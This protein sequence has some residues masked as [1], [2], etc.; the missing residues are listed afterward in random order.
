[1]STDRQISLD[2]LLADPAAAIEVTSEQ[3]AALLARLGR[4]QAMLMQRVAAEGVSVA[5]MDAPSSPVAPATTQHAWGAA[6][7]ITIDEA[8]ALLRVPRRWLYRNV[9]ALPFAR[10][11]SRKVL[12]FS[13]AGI[14]RWLA[15]KR[16]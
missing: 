3:A 7:L 15:T 5:P 2:V 10:K 14:S 11:L 4:V 13:R 9:R 16:P 6:D 12:R 8:A 1:M